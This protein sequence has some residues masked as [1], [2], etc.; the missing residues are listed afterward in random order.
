M[1]EISLHLLD[2]VRNSV[3]AGADRIS[4]KLSCRVKEDILD[5]TIEDNGRGMDEKLLKRVTDPFA[6]T[7]TTRKVGLGI[8]LF[9]SAAESTGGYFEISSVP[10]NGTVVKAGFGI[11]S[12]DRLPLGDLAGIITDLIMSEP[13]INYILVLECKGRSFRMDTAEIVKTLNGV[14]VTEYVVLEWIREY[15]NSGLSEIFGGVLDEINS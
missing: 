7:R 14:P 10:G 12:I 1:K 9:M 11:S 8:P 3:S 4:I 2:I 6:T 5:I 15:L 13:E